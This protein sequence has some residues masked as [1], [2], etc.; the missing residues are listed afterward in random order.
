MGSTPSDVRY[1]NSTLNSR[2]LGGSLLRPGHPAP[3]VRQ[4]LMKILNTYLPVRSDVELASVPSSHTPAC[5]PACSPGVGICL[6]QSFPCIGIALLCLLNKP[7]IEHAGAKQLLLI[8]PPSSPS[9]S[10]ALSI[11][12]HLPPTVSPPPPPSFSLCVQGSNW[13]RAARVLHSPDRTWQ[14]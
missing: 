5:S 10:S 11:C 2:S 3:A 4:Y 1:I 8:L 7:L 12:I 14:C 9:T 13:S 6:K